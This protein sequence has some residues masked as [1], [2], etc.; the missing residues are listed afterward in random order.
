LLPLILLRSIMA[1]ISAQQLEDLRKVLLSSPQLVADSLQ[2]FGIENIEDTTVDQ[3][4]KIMERIRK[5]KLWR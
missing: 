4:N 5:L 2:V 1:K 3:F